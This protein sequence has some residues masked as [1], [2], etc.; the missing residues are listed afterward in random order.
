MSSSGSSEENIQ[1]SP[2]SL[3]EINKKL[4]SI[5]RNTSQ[6][7]FVA[8]EEEDYRSPS[9]CGNLVVEE[10]EECDC[11]LD[12][13]AC[14]DPCCYPGLLS[15]SERE[16]NSSARPCHRHRAGQC[17]APWH[18]SLMFGLLLPWLTISTITIL[19][20]ILLC[21]DWR[22]NKKLFTHLLEY[23][24]VSRGEERDAPPRER[25]VTI[26]ISNN[27]SFSSITDLQSYIT[28]P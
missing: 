21:F 27:S 24:P 26:I 28:S 5:M 16:T 19:L 13:R 7:C 1:F 4:D 11:G 3:E 22:H 10:G 9:F 2:C 12:V 8:R 18:T 23:Q 17:E 20:A 14:A 15:A 6:A 25:Y